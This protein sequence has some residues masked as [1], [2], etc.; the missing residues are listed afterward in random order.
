MFQCLYIILK[1]FLMYAKVKKIKNFVI[2]IFCN[3]G[4]HN[5]KLPEDEI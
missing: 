3:F 2:F 1:E 5:K 4:T